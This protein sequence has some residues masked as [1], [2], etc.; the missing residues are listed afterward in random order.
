MSTYTTKI[1]TIKKKFYEKLHTISEDDEEERK[2]LYEKLVFELMKIAED[3]SKISLKHQ[4]AKLKKHKAEI[5]KLGESLEDKEKKLKERIDTIIEEMEDGYKR[6]FK[7][8][9]DIM[10]KEIDTIVELT[11]REVIKEKSGEKEKTDKT[12][13]QEIVREVNDVDEATLLYYLH[14]KDQE[15]YRDYE[16][17]HVARGEA[18]SKAKVLMAREKGLSDDMIRRYFSSEG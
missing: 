13:V 16:R 10:K 9:E 14:S 4:D 5:I 15:Y 3:M 7:G 2:Q 6:Q 17:K 1:R 8:I 12:N 11:G 18:I